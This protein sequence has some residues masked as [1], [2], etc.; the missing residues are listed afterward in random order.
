MGQ[1][2]SLIITYHL[3]E[4]FGNQSGGRLLEQSS[5]QSFAVCPKR[6]VVLMEQ[7]RRVQILPGCDFLQEGGHQSL[8]VR[9]PEAERD[10]HAAALQGNTFQYGK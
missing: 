6:C 8:I 4:I 7:V 1:Q 3:F 2:Y 5:W 9:S 10:R